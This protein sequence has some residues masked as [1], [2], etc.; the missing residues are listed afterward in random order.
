MATED[1]Q[2]R[3]YSDNCQP[4]PNVVTKKHISSNIGSIEKNLEND[5]IEKDKDSKKVKY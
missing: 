2:Q 3:D 4:A 5:G 1:V